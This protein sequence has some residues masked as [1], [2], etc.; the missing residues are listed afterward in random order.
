M[1]IFKRF[2]KKEELPQL[3]FANR[4][5]G[6]ILTEDEEAIILGFMKSPDWIVVQ[7][8]IDNEIAN[9]YL[10]GMS[11]PSSMEEY[12]GFRYMIGEHKRFKTTLRQIAKRVEKRKKITRRNHGKEK[13][14]KG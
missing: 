6:K 2:F 9:L 5:E 11:V 13:T 7:K 10:S 14:I 1:S 12:L 8:L 3:D 4:R